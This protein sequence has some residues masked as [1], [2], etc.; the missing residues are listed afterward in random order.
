MNLVAAPA[1]PAEVA[2]E[3]GCCCCCLCCCLC[4]CCCCCCHIAVKWQEF[5][6]S[7]TDFTSCSSSNDTTGVLWRHQ[8]TV[9]STH[10]SRR[11][12]YL[13]PPQHRIGATV[14]SS[15]LT[16]ALQCSQDSS[17]LIS[18]TL[19]PALNRCLTSPAYYGCCCCCAG[20]ALQAS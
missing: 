16:A 13:Q 2:D 6:L 15:V 8:H 19:N 14:S 18:K 4:C 9:R 7:F 12:E 1:T 3:G 17:T 11:A 10:G 5:G 20:I